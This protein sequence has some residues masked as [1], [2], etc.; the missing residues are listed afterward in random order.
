MA[1]QADPS[2]GA[3]NFETL[4]RQELPTLIALAT[5]MTGSRD[6]GADLAHE[7]LARA[8]RDWRTV[9]RLER[10]GAWVRRVL[11]NLTIDAHRR[12]E[13]ETLAL[14]LLD[15]HPIAAPAEAVGEAF[16]AAVRALPERQRAAVAL[17]YIEDLS[18]T[19]I[20]DILG[21]A[22]GT[23]KTSLFMARRS[24]AVSLGAEEVL[25]DND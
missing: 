9:G 2:A 5:T 3:A 25:D 1:R 4:Y 17:Y 16:W 19:E 10:P 6:V 20:A 18:I 23:V 7:A 21:V 24:L 8:Y 12:R 11:I 15:A 22:A 14:A 13:R